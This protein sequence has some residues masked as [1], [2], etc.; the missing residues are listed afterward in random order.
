MSSRVPALM[1]L[2]SCFGGVIVPLL[3]FWC[4][5]RRYAHLAHFDCAIGVPFLCVVTAKVSGH[6][7]TLRSSPTVLA[8]TS[9]SGS[10]STRILSGKL[11]SQLKRSNAFG[12]VA[13]RDSFYSVCWR[14]I[15]VLLGLDSRPASHMSAREVPRDRIQIQ[16]RAACVFSPQRD[17][18]GRRSMPYLDV[19]DP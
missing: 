18:G 13:H 6:A 17:G 4:G 10:T 11:P 1:N 7:V 5:A 3:R 12:L 19:S 16:D 2:S 9:M 8:D 14:A 15:V